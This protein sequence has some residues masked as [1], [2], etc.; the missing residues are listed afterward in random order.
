[1]GKEVLQPSAV[2]LRALRGPE[3]RSTPG[4]GGRRSAAGVS[5][6]PV[7][8]PC[9]WGSEGLGPHGEM[10]AA[11]ELCSP[12]A[13]TARALPF[14]DQVP[15]RDLCHRHLQG[16]NFNYLRL[17]KT[18]VSRVAAAEVAY[19]AFPLRSPI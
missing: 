4:G 11:P 13:G 19:L 1:M 17:M 7:P 5:G 14:L 9:P 16:C 10:L 3:R 12:R 2:G 18:W 8:R 6:H 15:L